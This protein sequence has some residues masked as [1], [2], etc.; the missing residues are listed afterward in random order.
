[1]YQ[2]TFKSIRFLSPLFLEELNYQCFIGWNIVVQPSISC[3][4]FFSFLILIHSSPLTLGCRFC[5]FSFV[6]LFYLQKEFSYP[7]SSD[8]ISHK[9]TNKHDRRKWI[10]KTTSQPMSFR[11]YVFQEH[12]VIFVY[13]V[14]SLLLKSIMFPFS[15]ERPRTKTFQ[16][17]V[18]CQ[19]L[20]EDLD[21]G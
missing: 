8:N 17:Y 20:R 13:A 5:S 4:A 15:S 3:K 11:N 21:T 12:I 19:V 14:F 10:L 7:R 2:F 1:M 16:A 9:N 18:Y 6:C